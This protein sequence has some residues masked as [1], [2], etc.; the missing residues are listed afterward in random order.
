MEEKIAIC[1][2]CKNVARS[3]YDVKYWRCSAKSTTNCITGN[4]YFAL[5]ADINESGNC[6]SFKEI[7]NEDKLLD[8]NKELKEMIEKHIKLLNVNHKE[9]C[10]VSQMNLIEFFKWQKQFDSSNFA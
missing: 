6:D 2:E 3:R 5:C 4:L 1:N 7:T 10:K 9:L 8:E